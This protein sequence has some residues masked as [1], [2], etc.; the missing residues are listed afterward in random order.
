M[1]RRRPPLTLAAAA[2]TAV[3]LS[4][5]GDGNP[6]MLAENDSQE[7]LATL[8]SIEREVAEGDCVNAIGDV[9]RLQ[10]QVRSLPPTVADRLRERLAQGASHLQGRVPQDCRPEEEATPTPTEAPTEVPTETPTPTA[11]PT[12]TPPP[13]ETEPPEPV[14][15]EEEGGEAGEGDEQGAEEEP[16]R[17]G[18]DVSEEKGKGKGNG[19]GGGKG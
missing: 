7:L 4:G 14:A 11:T 16:G 3:L 13:A 8:D 1:P 17:E 19:K 15:P 12:P 2:F 5:C 9:A 18:A 6:R 10:V